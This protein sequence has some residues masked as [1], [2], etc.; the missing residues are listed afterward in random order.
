MKFFILLFFLPLLISCA[1]N[2][3]ARCSNPVTSSYETIEV[4]PKGF[5]N[6]YSPYSCI[7][8]PD[9]ASESEYRV[10]HSFQIDVEQGEFIKATGIVGISN[11]MPKP[12]GVWKY[13]TLTDSPTSIDG[14]WG[15]RPMNPN[16][17]PNAHHDVLIDIGHWEIK[18][19]ETV[20]LNFVVYAASGE[21]RLENEYITLDFGYSNF[22][23]EKLKPSEEL[24]E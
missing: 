16:I 21:R 3:A 24:D 15:S 19:T 13:W 8:A 22:L 2:A 20:F 1:E 9:R 10:V 23:F 5:L 18:E 12:M 17:T 7:K 6:I 4:L 14:V 11:P